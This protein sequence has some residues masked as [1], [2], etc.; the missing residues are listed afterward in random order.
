MKMYI[1]A[2]TTAGLLV[3]LT[4]APYRSVAQDIDGAAS[5]IFGRPNDPDVRHQSSQ[6]AV[7]GVE[8]AL[9]LANSA[10]NANPPRYHDAEV[11]Y[12]LAA[13]MNPKDPRTLMGLGNIWYDQQQYAAA[14]KMYQQALSMM[15]AMSSGGGGSL[16]G[17]LNSL[18]QRRFSAQLRASFGITLLQSEDLAKAQ[19]EFER[20][21]TAEPTNPRWHALRG[22]CLLKQGNKREATKS[23]REAVR[24]DPENS[25]Y[26]QFLQ[27]TQ[28]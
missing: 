23:F 20:A 19:T 14:A 11:A 13:K 24:L 27:S 18:E 2:I 10:R 6:R 15:T 1:V 7:D 17:Q 4:F 28:Q 16:R 12:R 8:D 21:V 22:Y 5:K 25:E 26:K 9:Q 3:N